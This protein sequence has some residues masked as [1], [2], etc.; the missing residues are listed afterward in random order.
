MLRYLLDLVGV[1]VFAV[2]GAL[3]AGRR[4]LDLIGVVVLGVVTAIGGGTI[5]DVLLD[6]H[7]IFWLADPNF[8][9]V[10]TSAAML[11]VAYVR[12]R[13][14]PHSAL[15]IADALGLALFSVAGAQVAEN[16]G[17]PAVSCILLGT[18]TGTAGGVVR[19][20]LSA[21]V[22][23]VLRRGNLYATAAIAGTSTYLLLQLGGASRRNASFAGM[24]VCVALRF[25]SIWW[26]L[27]LP[28]FQ[29]GDEG[30][31]HEESK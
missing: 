5:R 28:V 15:L 29:L 14:A 2:S 19:D 26:G 4:G 25:A 9:I 8:L 22:P 31:A 7:P 20:V 10:I 27:K 23:L 24:I 21:E 30:N 17:L 16:A 18:V 12:W 13:P 6:R 11:T 1:A 3:A